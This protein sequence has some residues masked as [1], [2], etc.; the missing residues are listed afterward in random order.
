MNLKFNLV[1]TI[2]VIVVVLMLMSCGSVKKT[3]TTI[4]IKPLYQDNLVTICGTYKNMPLDC[5]DYETEEASLWNTIK[6]ASLKKHENWKEL[7]VKLYMM[8]NELYADLYEGALILD[9]KKLRGNVYDKYYLRER[10]VKVATLFYGLL[11]GL[12]TSSVK[13]G[14]SD[15]DGLVAFSQSGGIGFIVVIPGFV[16]DGGVIINEYERVYDYD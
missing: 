12:G 16:A 4:P 11:N 7:Q 2:A 5:A 9:T 15:S 14:V 6:Y 10:Q 3:T 8:N 13:L 1:R